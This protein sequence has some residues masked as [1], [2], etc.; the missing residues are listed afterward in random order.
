MGHLHSVGKGLNLH[1]K[2][3]SKSLGQHTTHTPQTEGRDFQEP[4]DSQEVRQHCQKRCKWD[5][6]ISVEVIYIKVTSKAK[7][8]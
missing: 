3:Y 5:S 2:T 7:E 8:I 6:N 4:E 1:K